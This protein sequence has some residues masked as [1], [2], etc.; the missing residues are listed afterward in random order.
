MACRVFGLG[1]V[2]LLAL[3][4]CKFDTSGLTPMS[5]GPV[6][7]AAKDTH[8]NPDQPTGPCK[9]GLV[10]CGDQC[11]DLR[12]TL[13]HCGACNAGCNPKTSDRCVDGTCRCGSSQPECPSGLDCQGERCV[14]VFGGRCNGCCDNDTCI[15]IGA[16]QSAT[17]CGQ[18][19][20]P[21]RNCETNQVC[22]VDSCS[23]GTCVHQIQQEG[24]QCDDG[25]WCT[26]QDACIG[27][28]CTGLPRDCSAVINPSVC[29]DPSCNEALKKCVPLCK[30]G[31]PCGGKKR[32][33]VTPMT[34]C[35]C[36][37]IDH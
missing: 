27:G 30:L 13:E 21:C 19:G 7:G 23:S 16:S 31:A 25:L 8:L 32:C 9:P 35:K 2:V 12:T 14:C 10:R 37:E 3:S 6:D 29:E 1:L 5:S 36:V 20:E 34:G 15:P 33:V 11:V 17:L 28:A 24:A 18:G 26:V 22:R 4:Q